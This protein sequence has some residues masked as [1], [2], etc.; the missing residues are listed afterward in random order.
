MKNQKN[1]YIKMYRKI[2]YNVFVIYHKMIQDKMK[3]SK[4]VKIHENSEMNK[5]KN[6]I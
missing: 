1:K 4:Y 5:A 6:K 2:Y 3:K